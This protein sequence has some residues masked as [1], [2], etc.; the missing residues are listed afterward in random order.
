[1]TGEAILPPTILPGV[2]WVYGAKPT[3]TLKSQ[4]AIFAF[5]CLDGLL[6]LI[7]RAKIPFATGIYFWSSLVWVSWYWYAQRFRRSLAS[8]PAFER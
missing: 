1:M 4:L 2:L 6:L 7:L 8:G 3:L 5:A